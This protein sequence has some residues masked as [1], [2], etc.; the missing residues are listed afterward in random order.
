MKALTK[1][2]LRDF[3]LTE[4][5]KQAILQK[6]SARDAVLLEFL[7]ATGARISEALSIRRDAIKSVEGNTTIVISGKGNKVRKLRVRSEILLR[8][9]NVYNGRL[10]LFESANGRPLDRSYV[11]KRVHGA[12]EKVGL[13]FSPHCARH[14]FATQK[15]AETGKINAV[16]RYLGHSS[17]AI[18]MSMYVHETLSDEE[19]GIG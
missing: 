14:T 19:L 17:S 1:Q 11:W 3:V 16:S 10:F 15:I 5:Q 8:I 7:F 9:Q 12:A 13:N 18:T 4:E 6:M 2:S